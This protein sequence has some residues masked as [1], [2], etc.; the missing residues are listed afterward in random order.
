MG[1]RL[2]SVFRRAHA[3]AKPEPKPAGRSYYSTR[4]AMARH[5]AQLLLDTINED[6]DP[7]S[8]LEQFE[9]GVLHVHRP[10]C[11]GRGAGPM[12]PCT[13]CD[14]TI[15]CILDGEINSVWTP[16]GP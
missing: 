13:E 3:A 5:L 15:I 1:R 7:N 10:G 12:N 9:G 6:A 4:G 8:Q 14:A 16:E 2:T 11:E